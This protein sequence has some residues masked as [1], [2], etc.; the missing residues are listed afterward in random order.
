MNK[1][2]EY[3]CINIG[4]RHHALQNEMKNIE[5]WFMKPLYIKWK[6]GLLINNEEL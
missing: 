1:S 3:L 2:V 5:K 6:Y 4:V